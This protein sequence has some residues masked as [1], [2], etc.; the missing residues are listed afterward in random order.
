ML[1]HLK[2]TPYVNSIKFETKLNVGGMVVS[3]A[4]VLSHRTAYLQRREAPRDRNKRNVG[5]GGMIF[6]GSQGLS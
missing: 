2:G 4:R 6:E 1:S 5:G 3:A